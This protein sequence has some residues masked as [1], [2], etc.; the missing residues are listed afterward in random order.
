M[1]ESTNK[2]VTPTTTPVDP[3]Y[4]IG[5]KVDKGEKVEKDAKG[6]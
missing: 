5:E 1:N 6:A 4:P 3:N 2:P